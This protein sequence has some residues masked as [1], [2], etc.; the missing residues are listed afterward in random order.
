MKVII[1]GAGPCGLLLAALLSK[2][3][4][5]VEVLEAS[6][7]L[8]D[9]PRACHYSAPAKY[10]LERAGVLGRISEEGFFPRSVCWRKKDGS[11]IVGLNNE[12]EPEDSLHR[13]VALELGRVVQ[14]LYDS[15][16]DQENAKVLMGHTVTSIGQDDS[17]AW[18][19]VMVPSGESSR[20]SADYIIGC[21][22]ANSQIRRSLFGNWEF[23]G[24]SW[25][26][27]I[28]ASNVYYDFDKYGYDDSNFIVHPQDWHMAARISKN[29]LWRVTYGD[30]PGLTK[31]QYV[32]RLPARYKEILP[33]QPEPS[34]YKVTNVGP[35]RM[36]QR[37]AKSLRVGRF[38]LAGDAAHL[39]NPFG[40]LGLTGGIADVGALYDALIGIH[41]GVADE[42]ILT[43]Y[44]E[45]RSNKYR[46]LVDPLSTANFRRLWEKDPETTIAEDEFFQMAREAEADPGAAKKMLEGLMQLR[47]DISQFY[48]AEVK[49]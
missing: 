46:T 43:Q 7:E 33:G 29:N 16:I 32:E 22:G 9:Q 30:V 15:A 27:Q 48:N 14:I 39:C 47:S 12:M 11:R 10:E 20:F 49:A 45:D 21:D 36:H 41:K 3:G 38:L 1:V 6:A 28:I 17:S 24:S 23:P 19:E 34:A 44:S 8:D 42:Q 13:M 37:L 4:V 26:Q 5:Q 35:Y 31:E 2:Q 25:E 40:G 18:V